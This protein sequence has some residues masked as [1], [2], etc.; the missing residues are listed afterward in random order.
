MNRTTLVGRLTK[1]PDVRVTEDQKTIA[2]FTLAINRN[3]KDT[4]YIPCV[5]FNK[6]AELVEKY[7]HKGDRIGVWGSIRT[8]KYEKDGRTVYTTDVYV[9]EIEFLQDKKEAGVDNNPFLGLPE[10]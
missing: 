5:A 7:F 9:D 3:K 4:D 2:R 1:D 8:G 6:T 10:A